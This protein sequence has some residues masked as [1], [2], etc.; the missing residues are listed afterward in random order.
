MGTLALCLA[1]RFPNQVAQYWKDFGAGYSC[2]PESLPDYAFTLANATV[3]LGTAPESP[4]KVTDHPFLIPD[5][6]F[7]IWYDTDFA[8]YDNL[9]LAE[10]Y[11][12]VIIVLGCGLMFFAALL[13]LMKHMSASNLTP[14]SQVGKFWQRH[15]ALPALF[16]KAHSRRPSAFGLQ[17][18]IPSRLQAIFLVAYIVLN[19]VFSFCSFHLFSNNFYWPLTIDQFQ[20]YVADRSGILAFAQFPFLFAFA[21][22]NT[23]FIWLTGWSYQSFST[24]HKWVARMAVYHAFVHAVVYTIAMWKTGGAANLALS[25]EDPYLRWGAVAIVAGFLLIS[26]SIYSLRKK[27][28]EIFVVSH[29]VMAIVW[30]VGSYYHVK[31][32]EEP[33]Y[34]PWIWTAVAFW[35]FDRAIRVLRLIAINLRWSSK[36]ADNRSTVTAFSSSVLKLQIPVSARWKLVPGQYVFLYF[37]SFKFWQSHPFSIVDISQH[38]ID[39]NPSAPQSAEKSGSNVFVNAVPNTS[40]R[41]TTKFMTVCFRAHKGVTR[42]LLNHALSANQQIFKTRALLEGPYGYTHDLSDFSTVVLVAAGLGI[43]AIVPFL[44]TMKPYQHVVVHWVIREA[45][46]IV[47]MRQELE[48]AVADNSK[49]IDITIHITSSEK[50]VEL[51]PDEIVVKYGKPDIQRLLASEFGICGEKEKIGVLSCGPGR[52]MDDARAGVCEALGDGTRRAI[53][54]FE[55]SFTW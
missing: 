9:F 38:A 50:T 5:D 7:S 11:G 13:R 51:S 41:S 1:Q 24:F 40:G 43:I 36:S 37:P 29:I 19:V 17:F 49:S 30:L 44:I 4:S 21:G 42:Q 46:S 33:V 25:Y 52:F 23:I 55:E 14:N 53:Q 54:Y 3:Y 15:I 8:Y 39:A 18:S 45:K 32:L 34:F 31:L 22:R 2:A 27:W 48:R 26:V 6:V 20:R 47:W 10:T 16:G 35:A 12:W 28:Y